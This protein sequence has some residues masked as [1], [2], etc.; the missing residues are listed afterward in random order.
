[1]E[2]FRVILEAVE[3]LNLHRYQRHQLMYLNTDVVNK[4]LS[5]LNANVIF[6]KPRAQRI[7][8]ISGRPRGF[9]AFIAAELPRSCA[10]EHIFEVVRSTLLFF[11][12]SSG[13]ILLSQGYFDNK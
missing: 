6:L 10:K 3:I 9:R 12:I 13:I 11:L 4:M 8:E 5:Y 1:M 2:I 7:F